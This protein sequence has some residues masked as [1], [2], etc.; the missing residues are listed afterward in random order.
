[1]L[2]LLLACS[3][4]GPEKLAGD[5]EVPLD[6]AITACATLAE[7]DRAGSCM[8]TALEVR[9]TLTEATCARVP[10]RWRGL[11]VLQAMAATHGALKRRYQ[12]CAAMPGDT[13]NCRFRLWQADV[14][15]LQPGHPDHA[16][17]L[18]GMREVVKRHR[19]HI[20]ETHP[21]IGDDMWTHFW[22]A[23][24]EQQHA[25]KPIGRDLDKCQEFPSPIDVR[26][27][28]KWAPSAFQ[29]LD[30]RLPSAETVRAPAGAPDGAEPSVP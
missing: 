2:W 7:P 18:E 16:M 10:G 3:V 19:F 22:G 17:E 28:R 4:S 15:A 1:M 24:W 25:T 13:R 21:G 30:S 29:W 5:G 12:D 14:L 23:W 20:A 8:V 6:Q 9:D 26:L 11:C 27:C